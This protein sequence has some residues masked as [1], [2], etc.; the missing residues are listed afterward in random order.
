[1]EIEREKDLSI[2]YEKNRLLIDIL[3]G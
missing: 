2:I 3:P 1:M